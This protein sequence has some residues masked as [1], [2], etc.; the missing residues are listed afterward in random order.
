MNKS[1][2]TES[3]KSTFATASKEGVDAGNGPIESNYK[4][5]KGDNAAN[6]LQQ[7]RNP[8]ARQFDD[9]KDRGPAISAAPGHAPTQMKV[10]A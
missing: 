2:T 1:M 6:Q 10:P 7:H 8:T 9:P 4:F 3:V 5:V